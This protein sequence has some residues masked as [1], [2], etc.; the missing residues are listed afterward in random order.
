MTGGIFTFRKVKL[1]NPRS[2]T[3]RCHNRSFSPVAQRK[4]FSGNRKETERHQNAHMMYGAKGRRG[5]DAGETTRLQARATK[6]RKEAVYARGNSGDAEEAALYEDNSAVGGKPERK[7]GNNKSLE[8]RGHVDQH[9]LNKHKL[10]ESCIFAT[11]GSGSTL[12]HQ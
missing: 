5:G 8:G 3:L 11:R 2:T 4:K 12:L 9:N 10:N 7:A 1:P 6:E